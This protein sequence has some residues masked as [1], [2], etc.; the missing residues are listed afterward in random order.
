MRRHHERKI[1]PYAPD[2]VFDLVADVERYPEFLPWCESLKVLSR[3]ARG[4]AELLTAE[5][6]IAFNVYRE[7]I[8][9]E[10]TLD[11]SARNIRVRYLK[12]PFKRLE[13]AW[14]FAGEGAG[15][16]VDFDITYEFKSTTLQMVVGFF[17]EEAVRRMVAAFDA[18]AAKLY[19]ERPASSGARATRS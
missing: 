11:R 7:R 3:E 10:V 14:Q 15:T 5:M 13:T 6:T 17:F 4:E 2:E 12:G 18:R 1:L 19:R 9:T 16:L 8:K